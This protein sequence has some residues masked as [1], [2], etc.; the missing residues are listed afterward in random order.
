MKK[1]FGSQ[2]LLLKF[3]SNLQ[4]SF[5]K[6]FNVRHKRFGSVFQGPFKAKRIEKDNYLLHLSRYIHLNPATSLL[7]KIEDLDKNP[8]TSFPFY[9]NRKHDENNLVNSAFITKMIGSRNKY[10]KFVYN[11]ADYQSKLRKIKGLLL[12]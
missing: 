1:A 9:L 5:A 4:N 7:I 3:I 2:F 12:E 8:W 11:Q 6:Y 10:K